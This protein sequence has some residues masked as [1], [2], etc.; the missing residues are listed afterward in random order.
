MTRDIYFEKMLVEFGISVDQSGL[1]LFD[2]ILIYNNRS[3]KAA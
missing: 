1:S 2:N 3:I